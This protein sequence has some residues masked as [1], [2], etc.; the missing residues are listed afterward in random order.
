MSCLLSAGVTRSCGFQFGGLK[1]VYLANFEEV[2]SV[3][4]DTDNQI[5]GVT[6]SSTGA[7]WYE[8]EYE[9]NTAQKL[10]ELQAGAVSRFVNQTLNMKLANVTQAKKEVIESLANAT[11]SVILQTQDDLYWFYAEPTLSAGLRATVLSIDSGT[12][13]ADDAAVTI[14]LVG[15][16]LGYANAISAA[17][18]AAAIA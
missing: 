12:A 7:T 15:G 6:M 5:T 18:V 11:V 1:K 2:S 17:A 13:Q 16:N 9:P 10:E 4:K 3:A 14:T 8:Y